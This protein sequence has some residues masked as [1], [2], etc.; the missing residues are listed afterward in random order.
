MKANEDSI[1]SDLVQKGLDEFKVACKEQSSDKI[2]EL[3]LKYVEGY[4]PINNR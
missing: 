1:S 4:N 2:K 3:L